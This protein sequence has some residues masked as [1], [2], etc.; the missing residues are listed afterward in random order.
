MARSVLTITTSYQLASAVAAVITIQKV[1]EGQILFNDV[2][3]D[4]DAAHGI[5]KIEALGNRGLQVQQLSTANT[6]VR[7]TG[8]GWEIIIDEG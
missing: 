6:Y 5:P 3:T 8:A 1:G 4:D 7:A 2:N